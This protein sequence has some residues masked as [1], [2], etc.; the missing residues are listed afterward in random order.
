MLRTALV[1]TLL[2]S[3]LSAAA[4]P[5]SQTP[6]EGSENEGSEEL[7]LLRGRA[8]WWYERH[9]GPDGS[10]PWNARGKALAQLDANTR[11]GLLKVK[12]PGAAPQAIQGDTWLPIGPRPIVNGNIFYAGRITALATVPGSPDTVYAGAAQGGVWKTT[13]GGTNWTPLTDGQNSLA[14]GALAIDPSNT[15]VVYA[16]TGEANQSC[17]SYYGIG[18]LKTTDGGAT[19]TNLGATT[20][21]NTSIAKIV[22]HPTIPSILWV[23]NGFGTAGFNCYVRGGSFGVWKSTNGGTSWAQ[24]LGG[25]QTGNQAVHD[26]VQSP[27]DPNVLYAA[28]NGIGIFKTTN[29]GKSWIKLAGGL[30]TTNVGRLDI[31]IHPSLPNVL[32]V[33][34]GNGSNGSQLGTYKSTDSGATWTTL[35]IPSGS[36]QFWDFQDI[37]TYSGGGGQCWYDLALEVQSETAVWAGG[38]ALFKTTNG[39][40]SWI[41][42]CPQSVH[43]DQHAIAFGS[44]GKVWIGNDGGVWASSNGGTTWVNK[45]GTLQ[46]TQFYPGA[47]LD[48]SNYERL[49]GGTQDNG[50]PRRTGGDAW[51]LLTLG[52]GAACVIDASSPGSTWYTSSQYLNIYKT[53]DSGYSYFSVVYGLLDAR[54]G[55][56]P[57][58]GQFRACPANSNVLIAGSDNVWRTTDGAG[59]WASNSPDPLDSS[60]IVTLAFAPSDPT[61]ATYAV[62]T[63]F[64]R[65]FRTTDA[66]ATWQNVTGILPGRALSDVAFDPAN[67]SVLYAAVSGFGGPHLYKTT[68]ALSPTPS[69]LAIDPGIPDAPINT[70]LVDPE[71]S[72]ILY[73]G[74]DLGLFKSEDGGGRWVHQLNG[75]PKVAIYD[76]VADGGTHAIVAFTHGRGAFRLN[77]VCTPPTF[78]GV[79]AAT[80]TSACTT[81]TEVAWNEPARWGQRALEGTYEVS[82]F[83][84]QDCTGTPTVV[85]SG[86]P[87]YAVSYSDTT[88]VPGGTYSYRVV[89]TNDCASPLSSVGTNTCSAPIVDA[90]DMV[91]CGSVGNTLLASHDA[92]DA[93]LSWGF[94]ACAD[95]AG[96]AI[97][98]AASYDAAFP[99]GWTLLGSPAEAMSSDPLTSPNV[100][101][102]VVSL[103]ACG[104]PSG[105]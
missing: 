24:V 93:T 32:Y 28:V 3:G 2:I 63:S 68:N 105:D 8:Q 9:R 5:P 61:C 43:V 18:L 41:D 10:I 91:P 42:V 90:A 55:V 22:V 65:V 75:I 83:D 85:A 71:A 30:P 103:D 50:T 87:T 84:G 78:D 49:M 38:T 52:D 14:I 92:T 46:I 1:L 89:A 94:V 35:P 39:G 13:D 34:V 70:V 74:S 57:F 29:D 31:G 86:L 95:L 21:Q 20:F 27:N 44:D 97:Y 47:A 99:S 37:C 6:R 88:T 45:N 76:L 82:R 19:W 17:D 4:E 73:A 48:P 98:G 51:S 80:D 62:G 102:R 54:T 79:E 69:W 96:Y 23:A 101:Y 81:G 67:A 59:T 58:I 16:G 53:I 64:G 36:C 26:L 40:T 11:S 15:N 60:R 77:L 66:G 33:I 100:A 7:A 104:N 25:A 12:L 72:N 56:A